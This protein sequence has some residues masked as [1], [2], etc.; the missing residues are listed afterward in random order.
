M[1]RTGSSW[2][3]GCLA[4]FLAAWPTGSGAEAVP[5]NSSDKA[6]FAR[7]K[8]L[9]QRSDLGLTAEELAAARAG[10]QLFAILDGNGD[11]VLTA[12]DGAPAR[13]V[14][15]QLDAKAVPRARFAALSPGRLIPLLDT[16]GD[17]RLTLAELR[18]SLG[19]NAPLDA[20]PPPLPRPDIVEIPPRP[21]SC[22][23]FGAGRWIELPANS[24]TCR[25]R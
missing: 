23:Y 16:D 24:S 21:Q 3:L 18:P 9:D 12:A 4:A 25:M 22:W 5:P 8:R 13:R 19:G 1:A 17:G 6:A 11:G 7:F 2:A 15:R 20:A 10:A 14:L